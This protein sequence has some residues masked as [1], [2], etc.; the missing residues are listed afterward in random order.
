MEMMKK[1]KNFFKLSRKADGGFTLVELIVVI[2]ILAILSGVAIP[3]YNGYVKKAERAAD[4]QLLAAINK[5]YA[6]A[7]LENETDM[8]LL[9]GASMP[10]N[11]DKTVNVAGVQPYGQ[12]FDLYFTGNEGT[13]FKVI[14][15]VVFDVERGMFCD[16]NDAGKVGIYSNGKTYNVNGEDAKKLLN[17]TWAETMTSQELLDMVA[18]NAAL[19]NGLGQYDIVVGNSNFK[20]AA[21]QLLGVSNYQE[22]LDKQVDA[23]AKAA[24]LAAGVT[25]AE[26]ED[27]RERQKDQYR[28]QVKSDVENNVNSN[29]IIMVAAKDAQTAG[30]DVMN[31][32]TANGGADAKD[33]LK[34]SIAN[35][36]NG[37]TEGLSQTVLA[38]GLYT[39]YVQTLD[40]TDAEKDEMLK[41]TNALNEFDDEGFQKYLES[42]GQKDLEGLLGAMNIISSQDDPNTIQ[43]T[44]NGQLNNSDLVGAL[45]QVLGK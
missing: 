36:N 11:A 12:A 25:E 23:A 42:Q 30:A 4:E 28:N 24:A 27:M 35:I 40:K 7:C 2:A 13:S 17:S 18:E 45:Q 6:A 3:A 19:V 1:M 29:M 32:L 9:S 44:V 37:E 10:L 8:A 15:S 43:S 20:D 22:Y 39:S 16:I 34:Q 31:I 5:A 38:Y 14:T 21:A 26:W 33:A 41:P